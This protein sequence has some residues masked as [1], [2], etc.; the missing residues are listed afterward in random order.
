M[1]DMN[2]PSQRLPGWLAAPGHAE[3]ETVP[4]PARDALLLDIG[5]HTGA[6]AI[7][8][9]AERD[10]TEIEVSPDREAEARTHN[11]VRARQV[12]KVTHYAAVFP[13]LPA[14]EYAIW[15][16]AHTRADVV[17]IHGGQVT[18]FRLSPGG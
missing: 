17:T 12:G 14:G 16:D 4:E 9:G 13:A 15:S 10:G 6:L 2:Q 7:Y 18:E 1:D 3:R 8:T 11:V 5:G